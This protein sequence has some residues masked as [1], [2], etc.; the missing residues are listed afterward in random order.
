MCG[1]P[2]TTDRRDRP[3]RFCSKACASRY[4]AKNRATTKGFTITSR[5]YRAIYQP[6]HPSA[7]AEGYVLEHRLV[8]EQVLGRPLL[9]TEVVHHKNEIRL[10]NR[11]ENLEVMTKAAHDRLPKPARRPIAC[12]HCGGL[13]DNSARAA[14]GVGPISKPKVQ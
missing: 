12:P 2:I 3:R 9:K 5:G 10:D 14:R 13:I 7:T 4:T 8:M 6:T 11:P 1:V